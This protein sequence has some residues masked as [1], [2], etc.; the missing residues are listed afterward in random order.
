[1]HKKTRIWWTDIEKEEITKRA[2]NIIFKN[3]GTSQLDALRRSQ[4]SFLPKERRR[5]VITISSVPWF[6]EL[7]NKEMDALKKALA[8]PPEREVIE[9][10][11]FEPMKLTEVPTEHLIS[12]LIRRILTAGGSGLVSQ[13]NNTIAQTIHNELPGAISR[14][15]EKTNVVSRE[16]LKKIL[17]IGLLPEQI[18]EVQ[19]MFDTSFELSFWTDGDSKSLQQKAPHQDKIYIM[20]RFISHNVYDML[21][22]AKVSYTIVPGATS[23]LC[24]VMEKYFFELNPLT[25]G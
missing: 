19:K 6:P 11:I 5:V 4:E 2:A 8:Q 7:L 23:E 1:M 17:V 18:N 24:A 14:L 10:V 12:E 13:V 25:A 21:K 16:H 3:P 20:K 9:Q 22:S 15:R